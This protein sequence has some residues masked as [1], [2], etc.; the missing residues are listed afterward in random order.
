MATP[1]LAI[2]DGTTRVS[3]LAKNGSGINCCEYTPARPTTK[4]DGVWADS[5]ISDGRQLQMRKWGNIIDV[6]T[7]VISG[8]DQDSIIEDARNLTELLEKAV[9]YWATEWQ[10]EP[11]WIERRGS[12]ETKTSYSLIHDY[13]WENDD[14]PFNPPFYTP[15]K[16]MAMQGIDLAIEHGFWLANPP[17]E[18][19]CVEISNIMNESINI[20]AKPQ[21][22]SDDTNISYY[23]S[24]INTDST[25]L[26]IRR[27]GNNINLDM[28]IGIR[29]RNIIVPTGTTII[30]AYLQVSSSNAMS[31]DYE[32]R[33]VGIYGELNASPNAFSTFNDFINRQRTVNH[34]T[35]LVPPNQ[36]DSSYL[37]INIS[38]V[39]QEVVDL[40][41]WT[42]GHDIVLFLTPEEN[43]TRIFASFDDT[44]PEPK[45][46][47][48]YSFGQAG[49]DTT[50]DDIVYV[51][52]KDSISMLS[53]IY[54]YDGASYSENLLTTELPYKLFPDPSEDGDM[55]YFGCGYAPIYSLAFD[56]TLTSAGNDIVWEYWNGTAW[57]TLSATTD[58]NINYLQFRLDGTGVI[59]FKPKN[60]FSKTTI[61]GLNY[62]WVRARMSAASA[63]ATQQNRHVYTI[64]SSDIEIKTPNI[65]GDVPAIAKINIATAD[66]SR[67]GA[68]KILI[69]LRSISRGEYFK[70]HINTNGLNNEYITVTADNITAAQINSDSPTG[71]VLRTSFVGSDDMKRRFYVDIN[72][73]IAQE[74]YGRYRA[75]ARAIDTTANLSEGDISSYLSISLGSSH[76]SKYAYNIDIDDDWY[77][78]DYGIIEL[79]PSIVPEIYYGTLR[80][81]L[82]ANNDNANA[83]NL[84]WVDLVL[85]P[86]DEYAMEIRQNPDVI[87]TTRSITTADSVSMIGKSNV[88]STLR[89]EDTYYIT[90]IPMVISSSPFQLQA[91]ANQ[92]LYFFVPELSKHEWVGRV[93]LWKNERYLT[94]RGHK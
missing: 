89:D 80:I 70:Q 75:F 58:R 54:R 57:S 15:S 26:M 69:G 81:N 42:S 63:N 48:N 43:L 93:S 3:L 49:V 18:S 40:P 17:G 46:I 30:S 77:Y 7:L 19:E 60:D 86:V 9:S 8:K 13:K 82:Y 35:W 74:Y 87:T 50:C 33:A 79:P 24:S 53:A 91:N 6:F 5:S 92:K 25:W 34:K 73:P 66:S 88:F 20:I 47:I 56:L 27:I 65:S 11:V 14:N 76:N 94:F 85:L 16:P 22:S 84:D 39:I 41:G 38:D 59:I 44:Y 55:C 12:N 68:K 90:D 45:L 29:F 28:E 72:P 31:T 61:N 83:V 1:I 21:Q 52:N 51:G 32:A 23:G 2:T 10:N 67:G 64:T 62:Y 37:S 78:F 36:Y 71:N 4:G